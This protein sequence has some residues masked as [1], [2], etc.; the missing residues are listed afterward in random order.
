MQCQD[1]GF[2]SCSKRSKPHS[3]KWAISDYFL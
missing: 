2:E 1:Q 3:E